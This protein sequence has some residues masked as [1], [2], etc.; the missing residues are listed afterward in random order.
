MKV[1][2]N[3]LKILVARLIRV[4]CIPKNKR[5][6]LPL[7]ILVLAFGQAG[8]NQPGLFPTATNTT[9]PSATLTRTSTPTPTP[10]PSPTRTPLPTQTVT[11]TRTA[12]RTCSPTPT[13]PT[14]TPTAT[15]TPTPVG[16]TRD[17]GWIEILFI[18]IPPSS[19]L[20]QT[21]IFHGANSISRG[22][23]FPCSGC[24]VLSILPSA[25]IVVP[26]EDIL[27]NGYNIMQGPDYEYLIEGIITDEV[28]GNMFVG[29][30][31]VI[32]VS[33]FERT[34]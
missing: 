29:S 6:V 22:S 1:F 15:T 5:A 9:I 32:D 28:I 11:P 25:T 18:N 21:L 31:P 23:M 14:R 4:G 8:C 19:Q 33:Y 13:G 34:R 24:Y 3:V 10:M 7:L 27:P 12:T 2:N 26:R 17:R 20:T 30:F 16:F